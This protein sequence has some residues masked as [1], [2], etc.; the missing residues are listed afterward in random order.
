MPPAA[1]GA[2]LAAL[3]IMETDP[4]LNE[5]L[6]A[7]SN[8]WKQGLTHAGF[9]LGVSETPITPVM[10]HDESRALRLQSLLLEEGV[11]ALAIVFPT[12]ALGRARLRT[13]PSAMHTKEDLDD[14][15]NA[16]DR[17]KSS[18]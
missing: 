8:Y 9:D 15:L 10:I 6:W 16:F 13:M 18:V 3:E 12:V 4:T 2:V 14:A 17:I 5:R 1:A 7:N 11:L